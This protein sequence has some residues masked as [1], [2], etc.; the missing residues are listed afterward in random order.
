M[1]ISQSNWNDFCKR[2][3]KC[4]SLF[5]KC[6]LC[7]FLW[8]SISLLLP[9]AN[10][11]K[12][13][14]SLTWWGSSHNLSNDGCDIDL[15]SHFLARR[16]WRWTSSFIDGID[17]DF[18]LWRVGNSAEGNSYSWRLGITVCATH[19]HTHTHPN[20]CPKFHCHFH[21]W[22]LSV[23]KEEKRKIYGHMVSRISSNDMEFNSI[24]C[25]HSYRNI[26]QAYF[27]DE[28]HICSYLYH[29]KC[30]ATHK[31][32]TWWWD[33]MVVVGGKWATWS[34]SPD[35]GWRW[36]FN[37]SLFYRICASKSSS[38]KNITFHTCYELNLCQQNRVVNKPIYGLIK[39]NFLS[40]D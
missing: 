32:L 2:H 18:L 21:F 19:T 7:L 40:I 16:T 6:P 14:M 38:I 20:N 29:T 12:Y 35:C 13:E 3:R 15:Q 17:F 26:G 25:I 1:Y 4:Y 9:S 33:V 39:F 23:Q 27:Y 36:G 10:D 37:R 28:P 31:W 22:W 8:L 34:L 30:A 5:T 11:F 24:G